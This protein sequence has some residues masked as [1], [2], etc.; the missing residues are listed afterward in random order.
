MAFRSPASELLFTSFSRSLSRLRGTSTFVTSTL[1]RMKSYAPASDLGHHEDTK[2]RAGEFMPVYVAVG[3]VLLSVS[4]GTFTAL[5]HLRHSPNVHVRKSRRETMPELCDPDR[6][7]KEG[8]EFIKKSF[9]RKVAHVQDFNLKDPVMP[10]PIRGDALASELR[11][12]TLKSV[13][14]DPK[15]P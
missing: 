8:D 13:G 2:P 7:V 1:P 12:E 9:F 14:I 11:A 4:I 5:H 15:P 10:D 6:T 3:M